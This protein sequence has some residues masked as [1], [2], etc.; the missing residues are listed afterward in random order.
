[1]ISVR[2]GTATQPAGIL[3]NYVKTTVMGGPV[4]G[5]PTW[6]Q[7]NTTLDLFQDHGGPVAGPPPTE[8]AGL[9]PA[10][11]SVDIDESSTRTIDRL[12]SATPA[13]ADPD[14]LSQARKWLHGYQCK[15]GPDRDPHPPDD[16]ILSQFLAVAPWEQLLR[17]I[18]DLM[19][20][21]KQPGSSYAWYV[22]VALQ[23]IHGIQP[24]V[25]KQRRA[26][27]RIVK[28][29]PKQAAAAAAS[30]SSLPQAPSLDLPPDPDFSADLLKSVANSTRGLKR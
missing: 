25:L 10:A 17:L 21:R 28:H 18:Y 1:M 26:E 16:R 8:N 7:N 22:S 5:P 12:L 29:T 27:L 23:R 2:P 20:E 3:L 4:L 14:L 11:R 30:A 9:A 24:Q 15:F 6:S 19:A 13:K